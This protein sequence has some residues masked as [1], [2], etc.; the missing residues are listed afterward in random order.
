MVIVINLR[1]S[2]RTVARKFSQN[3]AT[4]GSKFAD[5]HGFDGVLRR[6]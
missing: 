3:R 5:F 6:G 1:F 4:Q 2:P